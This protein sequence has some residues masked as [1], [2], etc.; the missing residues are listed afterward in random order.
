MITLHQLQDTL[1]PHSAVTGCGEPE[2]SVPP[3][4]VDPGARVVGRAGDVGP[5]S[6]LAVGAGAAAALAAALG[7]R[8]H[9][10]ATAGAVRRGQHVGGCPR[11]SS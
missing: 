3:P 9:C 11:R 2:G 8:V 4:V 7:V 6:I 1:C 10:K 5:R